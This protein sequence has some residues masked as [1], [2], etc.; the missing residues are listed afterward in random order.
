MIPAT[1]ENVGQ[2]SP[3]TRARYQLGGF[4][5]NLSDWSTAYTG[6]EE[7]YGEGYVLPTFAQVQSGSWGKTKF[8][9]EYERDGQIWPS[10][11]RLFERAVYCPQTKQTKL[12]KTVVV[13]LANDGCFYAEEALLDTTSS[14]RENLR[15]KHT[16]KD[17]WAY[18]SPSEWTKLTPFDAFSRQW[19]GYPPEQKIRKSALYNDKSNRLDICFEC[20]AT[21][22]VLEFSFEPTPPI[23]AEGDDLWSD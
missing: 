4:G 3:S 15:H 13:H 21:N 18:L 10:D 23:Q 11:V 17:G 1:H 5:D 7:D 2:M 19:Y 14:N 12:R 8:E 20:P 9:L 16:C 6:F 22:I